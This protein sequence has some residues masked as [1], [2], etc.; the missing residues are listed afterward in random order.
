MT[1]AAARA[2]IATDDPAEIRIAPV[3]TRRDLDRFIRLPG[4]LYVGD[5]G[6]VE[7]LLFE[8]RQALS[9]T[10]NPYFQH[11]EA[12]FWLASRNGRVVGRISA[13][14]DKLSLERH[15]DATGHFG[16]LDVEDDAATFAALTATAEDWLRAHGM[17][18]VRGPFNLSINEESGLLVEGF[19]T[20]AAM[21][22]GYAPPYA[23]RRIEALGYVKAKDLVAYDYDATQAPPGGQALLARAAESKAIEVRRLNLARYREDL[24]VILDIFNDAWSDNW[25]FVP[26]TEAEMA[27]IANEM[28]PLI[29][30]EMVWIASLDGVPA[31]MIVCLPNLNEAIADLDGRLLPFGWL[32]LLWR[33][34]VRGL[35][36]ARVVMMGL[37]RAHRGT[38]L[39]SAAVLMLI[40]SLRAGMAT[41]GYRQAELSWVL[42]DNVAMRRMIEGIGGRAYKV[43]RVYEKA[44]A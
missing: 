28:R 11:A 35:K 34:K 3:R 38:P 1:V 27:R 10:R 7:P 44:L 29:R 26:F 22:M 6:F 9:R 23:G 12:E 37:R 18:R 36:S 25:G 4:R 14:I 20:P 2:A 15:G 33:L 13:Q 8:R 24:R 40:E 21:M 19:D 31:A 39:G 32:K 16:L 42:E 17:R 30:S 41:L 5:A 43:Y